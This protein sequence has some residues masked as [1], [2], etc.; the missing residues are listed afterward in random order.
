ML[1]DTQGLLV[2]TNSPM[3]IA[4]IDRF[5]EQSL[6]YGNDA[7]V[8]LEGIEADPT[9][10]I[11]NAYAAGHYLSLE[12]AE[13]RSQAAPYLRAA[14]K[15]LVQPGRSKPAATKGVITGVNLE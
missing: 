2:T 14:K 15:Y 7:E 5:V 3:A 12:S 8:I 10:V 13:A 9:C 11:A 1:R 6:G 4:A